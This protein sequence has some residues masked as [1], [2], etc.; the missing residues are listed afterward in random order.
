MKTPRKLYAVVSRMSGRPFKVDQDVY[1]V[2]SEAAEARNARNSHGLGTDWR[3]V[4]FNVDSKPR[5]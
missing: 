5:T 3:V 1:D 4:P 2:R